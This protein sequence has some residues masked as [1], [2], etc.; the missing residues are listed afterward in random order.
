MHRSAPV[1]A[2]PIGSGSSRL[3]EVCA[4]LAW[5][6]PLWSGVQAL[7]V[8]ASW[9][10]DLA[11]LRDLGMQPAGSEGALSTL[12]T[13]LV[14]LAPIGGRS[15][16]AGLVGVAALAVCA[17][18][19]FTLARRLLAHAGASRFDA[20][21]ALL[22]SQLWCSSPALQAEA[23]RL[24]GALPGLA[25]LLAGLTAAIGDRRRPALL[26]G[27]AALAFAEHH[28]AGSALIGVCAIA[29]LGRGQRGRRAR[30]DAVGDFALGA[31]LVLA[32][33]CSW[34]A[35]RSLSPYVLFDFGLSAR[36]AS[37]AAE[38]A[39]LSV[40]E[41]AG[42]VFGDWIAALG[43]VPVGLAL[44]G[45]AFGASKRHLR[46]EL[47]ALCLLLLL[48]GTKLFAPL[49]APLSN[50]G[51]FKLSS[52]AALAVASP[53]L[54]RALMLRLWESRIAGARPV[55]AL[56]GACAFG[57]VVSRVDRTLEAPS[58][59]P[60]GAEVWTEEALGRLPARALLLVSEPALL[61]RLIAARAL[62]GER[63][64]VV[65]VPRGDL[66]G[67]ASLLRRLTEASPEMGPLLRQLA[68]SG[69]ADEYSLSL[70]AD[71]R[72]VFVELD[73]NWERRLLEHL[74][75]AGLWL[76]LAPR[77]QGGLERREGAE[78][79]LHAFHRVY[80]PLRAHGTLDVSTRAALGD[81]AM[82]QALVLGALGDRARA[83]RLL[84]ARAR[85]TSR[86][87]LAQK[88]AR[89]LGERARGRVR[90]ADL[91]N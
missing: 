20:L 41:V 12:L 33:F 45:L 30:A 4:W 29:G 72:P 73:P 13:Q 47:A 34:R 49:A 74:R 81:L 48:P 80:E 22:S 28:A 18:L 79:S 83:R 82:Q 17:G 35:L 27:L 78:R 77:A 25:L 85:W 46:P 32:A 52:S 91:M 31:V 42:Q 69:S 76:E 40:L 59:R 9:S 70:L 56:A 19:V 53:L 62:H 57:L 54:S 37:A 50:V 43:A 84:S 10:D 6:L 51:L 5:T 1:D 89:R 67:R 65:L 61:R 86:D 90:V 44:A 16:R 88:L 11:A 39:P 3:D 38:P 63:P 60:L 14:A 58:A 55:A 66:L 68:V 21:W 8:G 87:P 64:D 26:G 23:I 71:V 7:G 2:S 36:A 15:F 24:G 75:P